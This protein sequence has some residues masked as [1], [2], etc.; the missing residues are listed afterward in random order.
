MTKASLQG[1]SSLPI[2]EREPGDDDEVFL[3]PG[4]WHFTTLPIRIRTV[5]GSC[6]SITL[7]HPILRAGGM[8]HY[9][10]PQARAG[11]GIES[12]DAGRYGNT[13]WALLKCAAQGIGAPLHEYVIKVFGGGHMFEGALASTAIADGNVVCAFELLA[14]DGLSISAQHVGGAG[15][16]SLSFDVGRGD[17]RVR[18]M[19]LPQ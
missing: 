12:V 11:V 13:A 2:A 7:W 14:A 8:C 5:L 10:L 4:Q 19:E 15:S 6:V 18:F 1:P 16:R 9:M 3:L 17:I